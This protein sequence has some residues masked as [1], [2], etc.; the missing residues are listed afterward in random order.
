VEEASAYFRSD[1]F[2]RFVQVLSPERS[3]VQLRT[4]K[5]VASLTCAA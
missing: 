5:I 4:L 2:E 1:L 3:I